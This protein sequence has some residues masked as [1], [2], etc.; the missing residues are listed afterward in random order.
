M[1][2]L[3]FAV[4]SMCVAFS[5]VTVLGDQAAEKKSA[6]SQRKAMRRKP[7]AKAVF[8]DAT[9]AVERLNVKNKK[10]GKLWWKELHEADLAEIKTSGGSYDL[11]LLGDSITHR[12]ERKGFGSNVLARLKEKYSVL[13]LGIGADMTGHVLWRITEGG[14]LD[15]YKAKVVS[16]MIG[17]NNARRHK[18]ENVAAAVKKIIDIIREKQ[19]QAKIV[20]TA[21][22]PRY[23]EAADRIA[24][25]KNNDA[26]NAAIKGYADSENIFWLDLN[27]KY[28]ALDGDWKKVCPDGTHPVEPGYEIWE[29]ELAPYLK[30][31]CGK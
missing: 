14:E 2:I 18:P 10:T 28:P 20:L 12:W 3:K 9:V 8:S 26:V 7:A 17:T 25:R 6:P 29:S 22:L 1:N 30:K 4:V 15:G 21:I 13:N 31:Y 5:A 27:P 23:G 11:V 24:M 16:L 19:P